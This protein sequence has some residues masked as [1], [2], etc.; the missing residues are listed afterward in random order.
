MAAEWEQEGLKDVPRVS[1]K[2]LAST[3]PETLWRPKPI[4]SPAMGFASRDVTEESFTGFSSFVPSEG[5]PCES[6][7]PSE[8]FW[9]SPESTPAD[10]QR[11]VSHRGESTSSAACGV[12]EA[13]VVHQLSPA[14]SA[15]CTEAEAPASLLLPP[16]GS[17]T[18]STRGSSTE[19]SPLVQFLRRAKTLRMSLAQTMELQ[20]QSLQLLLLHPRVAPPSSD[21]SCCWCSAAAGPQQQQPQSCVV[22][23][24]IEMLQEL[25]QQSSSQLQQQQEDLHR[26]DMWLY[27]EQQRELQ[28][29]EALS[30][31]LPQWQPQ[32][33][34]Q[35]VA[36]AAAELRIRRSVLKHHYQQLEEALSL[37]QRLQQE[38]RARWLVEA[39]DEI[40]TSTS[41]V[42]LVFSR[43]L[44][45]VNSIAA[46][47]RLLF[48]RLRLC[49]SFANSAV[50]GSGYPE[51]SDV[52]VVQLLRPQQGAGLWGCEL[53][54]GLIGNELREKR[55]KLL[56]LEE[57]L[58]QLQRMSALLQ[59]QQQ[60]RQQQQQQ[61]A[62]VLARTEKL[63]AAACTDLLIAHKHRSQ[64]LKHSLLAGAAVIVLFLFFVLPHTSLGSFLAKVSD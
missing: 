1:A 9:P 44:F 54:D 32:Q 15:E 43:C 29:Q 42:L 62:A 14:V 13:V 40:R 12:N 59:L 3:S 61:V 64:S 38:V 56:R 26:G 53:S 23:L 39:A 55:D 21:A 51:A 63:T 5:I 18:S 34:S 49:L 24:Q 6:T 57:S 16:V 36:A 45:V 41:R 27:E 47:A 28:H 30:V 11:N 10:I 37:Q 35:A 33:Q 17:E 25:L 31:L 4:V 19:V 48:V 22:M 60:G 2:F 20:Q 8:N 46:R 58:R 52:D 7:A 50:F